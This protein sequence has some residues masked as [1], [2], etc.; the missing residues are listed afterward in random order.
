[1]GLKPKI[2]VSAIN[3]FEGGTLS[4]LNDCVFNLNT[5]FS[6]QF[7]IIV[8][9][10]K[11]EILNTSGIT[12]MEFPKSRNSYINRIYY[13]YVYF[14]KL[15]KQIAP[16]LWISL[17]DITPN[18]TAKKQVVYCHNPSLFFKANLKD[19]YFDPM[20]YLFT[21]FYKFLYRINIKKNN[22]VIV[23]QNWINNEFKRIYR[24]KNVL[25]AYPFLNFNSKVI[26]NSKNNPYIFFFPSVP[27]SFK[28]LEVI[29]EAVKILKTKNILEFSVIL[30]LDG[31]ENRYSRYIKKKYSSSNEIK[32]I[33]RVSRDEVFNIYEN[34]N[35]LIF[36]SKLETWG[37]PITEFKCYNKPIIVSDLPYAHETVGDYDKVCFFNP[38]SPKELASI[39]GK[40]I[41]GDNSVFNKHQA[42]NHKPDANNWM[43]L[44]EIIINR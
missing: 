11:K 29:G 26:N 22:Y 8:L 2:V 6:K 21:L 39:M 20:I 27:R 41:N 25:T 5:Y 17:N 15:S 37:L 34:A 18:V 43:E 23:Q 40:A 19:L 1:M 10:F 31:S 32:F 30:T 7:E 3:I 9:V 16:F 33:G 4:V 44:L 28:N 38:D 12:I 24:I 13:E 35:C 14:R 36:P 42:G